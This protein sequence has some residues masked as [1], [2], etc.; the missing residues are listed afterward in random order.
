MN[1][2]EKSI[3][4]SLMKAKGYIG[5]IHFVDSNRWAPGFGYTDFENILPILKRINYRSAI[6]IE[7]LPKPD[8]YEAARQAI[9]YFCS[10]DKNLF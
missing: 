4:E 8:D 3:E 10:L 1:I 6:S 5:Y 2:E 7:V 9:N